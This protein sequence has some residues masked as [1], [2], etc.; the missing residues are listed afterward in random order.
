MLQESE[1]Q[2]AETWLPKIKICGA[3]PFTWTLSCDIGLYVESSDCNQVFCF[4]PK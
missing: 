3:W 4:K 2:A 1:L